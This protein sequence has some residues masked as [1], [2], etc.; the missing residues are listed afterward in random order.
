MRRTTLVALLIPGTT[1]LGGAGVGD[2]RITPGPSRDRVEAG[3]GDDII[4]ARDSRRDEIDCGRDSTRCS[5]I[6]STTSP[7]TARSFAGREGAERQ[8]QVV[9]DRAQRDLRRAPA[10]S[11]NYGITRVGRRR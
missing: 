10:S 8:P 2:D 6:A 7:T 11:C 1:F 4:F 3:R 5:P 9:V